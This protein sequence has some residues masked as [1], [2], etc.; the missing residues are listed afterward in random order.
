MQGGEVLQSKARQQLLSQFRRGALHAGRSGDDF[1]K[2]KTAEEAAAKYKMEALSAGAIMIMVFLKF[3]VRPL[4]SVNR[5]SSS[6]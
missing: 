2:R 4:L 3:T 1:W 6:T 5:P